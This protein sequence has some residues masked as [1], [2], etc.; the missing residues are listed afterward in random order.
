MR[1]LGAFLYFQRKYARRRR[2]LIDLGRR[3]DGA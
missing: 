1:Q 2:E 3:L